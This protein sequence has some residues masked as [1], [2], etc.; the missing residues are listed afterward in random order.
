MISRHTG[1][2]LPDLRGNNQASG[3]GNLMG[4]HK[5]KG[6]RRPGHTFEKMELQLGIKSQSDPDL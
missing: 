1:Q 4:F 3:R 2:T 5:G 6:T